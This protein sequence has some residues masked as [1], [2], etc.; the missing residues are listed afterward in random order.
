MGSLGIQ[1]L[2]PLK[3]KHLRLR[4]VEP[5][6]RQLERLGECCHANQSNLASR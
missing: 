6:E 4:P 2:Q 5:K 1:F 3:L